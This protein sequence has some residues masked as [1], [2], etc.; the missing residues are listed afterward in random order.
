MTEIRGVCADWL[1]VCADAGK[2]KMKGSPNLLCSSDFFKKNHVFISCSPVPAWRR[3]RV[4]QGSP[5]RIRNSLRAKTQLYF[6]SH[7]PVFS[8]R[9][10]RRVGVWLLGTGRIDAAWAGKVRDRHVKGVRRTGLRNS[11]PLFAARVHF[12]PSTS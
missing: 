8:S 5:L 12:A 10:E 9:S 6:F 11:R 2:G 3:L 1:G 7:L 4:H